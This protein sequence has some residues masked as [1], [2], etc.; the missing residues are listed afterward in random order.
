MKVRLQPIYADLQ[1]RRRGICR[2][3]LRL[4]VVGD[5]ND[6][7]GKG[8]SGG[9]ITVRP[10]PSARFAADKNTI[11]GIQ[12]YM[13]RHQVCFW[14]MVRLENA[15]ASAILAQQL[16]LRAAGQMAVNI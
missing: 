16:W 4:D 8:L 6:Y 11:V 2:S 13:G 5:A 10:G 3:G 14:Q 12:F 9:M 1:V 7:V 15:C